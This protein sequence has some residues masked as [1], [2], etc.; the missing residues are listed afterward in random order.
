MSERE[1]GDER[2]G[3]GAKAGAKV[4]NAKRAKRRMKIVVPTRCFFTIAAALNLNPTARE[5]EMP[6]FF[7]AVVIES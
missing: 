1:E 7:S 2:E 3:S 5:L 4:P 6:F